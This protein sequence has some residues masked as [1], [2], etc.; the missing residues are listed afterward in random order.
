M[1]DIEKDTSSGVEEE[2]AERSDQDRELAE[3]LVEQAKDEGLDLVGPDGVL[4][5]LTKRVLEAGLEAEMTEHLGYNKHASR[6]A[7]VRTPATA[8]DPRRW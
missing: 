5:G 2:P 1:S 4:T 8:P 7:M 6:G 3:R